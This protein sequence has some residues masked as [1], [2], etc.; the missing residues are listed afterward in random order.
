MSLYETDF[1]SWT[2][3]QAQLLRAG[4]W[5]ALDRDNLAEEIETIG[6]QEREQLT[7][8]FGILLGHL[9]KWQYQ[10]ERRSNSWRATIKDQRTRIDRL[11]KQNPSLKP[12]LVEAFA[13]GYEDAI[14][15]A[16]SETELPETTFPATCPYAIE[17][18]LDR[19]FLPDAQ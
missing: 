14:N 12:Y 13:E 17:Q 11:L 16:V 15:L 6:R 18:A 4:N 1:Y 9:L 2:Q 19:G 3:Q 7:N 8:R 5:T 10:P